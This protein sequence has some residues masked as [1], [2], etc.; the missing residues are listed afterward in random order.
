MKKPVETAALLVIAVLVVGAGMLAI[1]QNKGVRPETAPVRKYTYTIVNTF[2]HDPNAFTEGLAYFDGFLYESTGLV[3]KSTLRRVDL[4]SGRVLTEVSLA[5]IYFGEGLAVVN[6][7]ILQLTW[8]SQVG[9]VYDRE[10]LALVGNFSYPT[11]GWGLTF[12]GSLLIMSDG[13]SSLYF[14][15]PVNYQRIGQVQVH[16]GN[17]SISSINELEYVDGDVYAN[18]FQQSRVAII[19]PRNGLVKSWIELDGLQDSVV[20]TGENVLN[21]IAFDA[22]D[23]RLFVTGKNWPNLYEITLVPTT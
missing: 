13:S 19:D 3:D 1:S 16:D 7:S 8:Q 11:E 20:F 17:T 22:K 21:G 9:F 12:N 18:I 4:A 14:L 5:G 15:D 23:N 10:S 2:P 6:D